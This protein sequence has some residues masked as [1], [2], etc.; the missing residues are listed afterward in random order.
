M[1]F[2]GDYL[3]AGKVGG[4]EGLSEDSVISEETLWI[5]KSCKF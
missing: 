4:V 5:I 2:S 3:S 1:H